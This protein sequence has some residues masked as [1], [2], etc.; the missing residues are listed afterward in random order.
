MN[1][2]IP[3]PVSESLTRLINLRQCHA[4]ALSYCA[5]QFRFAIAPRLDVEGPE[6]AT[7]VC[8]SHRQLLR[9]H[10]IVDQMLLI[11]TATS[12]VVRSWPSAFVVHARRH[13]APETD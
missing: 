12:F 7:G 3:T 6:L 5:K 4:V 9:D 13:A 1:G 2:W 11:D 10:D 8:I